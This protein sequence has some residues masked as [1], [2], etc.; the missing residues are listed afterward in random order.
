MTISR[1]DWL[2]A[3]AEIGDSTEDDHDAVTILEFANLF[4]L[5]RES[6]AR[7]LRRLEAAGR[8][9]RTAKISVGVD[10]RR[11]RLIAFRLL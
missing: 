2:R 9:R 10:G 5:R 4:G 3:M 7:R 11:L 8:A 1:D 6:A